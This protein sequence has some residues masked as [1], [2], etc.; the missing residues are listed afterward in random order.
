MATHPS[1][2]LAQN[3]GLPAKQAYSIAAA[4]LVVGLLVGYFALG[5]GAKAPADARTQPASNPSPASTPAGTHPKLTLEEMKQMADVQASKLIEQSKKDPKNVALL[6]QVATVYQAAHQFKD[7][8]DY[9]QKAL[10]IDPKNV[11]AR[12]ELASCLY[13]SGDSD[14]ALAQLNQALKYSP[15][16]PNSLFNLGMIKYRGKNDPRGAIAAW[17]ELLKAHPDLDR[18][19]AVEAMITEAQGKLAQKN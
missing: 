5:S 13:Y 14:G 7:A 15:A 3:P 11:S 16:D 17:Q 2:A 10:Q 8:A 9:F 12:T 1:P 18:K 6:V 4:C 19:A